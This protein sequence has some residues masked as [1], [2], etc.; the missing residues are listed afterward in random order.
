MDNIGPLKIWMEE[1]SPMTQTVN[2]LNFSS[3]FTLEQLYNIP[4]S[5]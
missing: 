5:V 2:T 1:L 4:Q 3:V